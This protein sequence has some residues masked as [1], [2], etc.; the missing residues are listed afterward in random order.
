MPLHMPDNAPPSVKFTFE[1]CDVTSGTIS[2][3]GMLIS[4]GDSDGVGSEQML[5]DHVLRRMGKKLGVAVGIVFS[6][7]VP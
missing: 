6:C 4:V 1:A 3:T 2:R 5:T 7:Y